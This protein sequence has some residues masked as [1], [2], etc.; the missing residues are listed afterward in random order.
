MNVNAGSVLRAVRHAAGTMRDSGRIITISTLN[1]SRP[2]AGI[3]AYVASKGAIEQLTK[4]A[5][6]GLAGAVSPS[7]RCAP[8]SPTPSC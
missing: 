2:R 6:I 8:A 3:A 4:V 1:T 7:T 5:A